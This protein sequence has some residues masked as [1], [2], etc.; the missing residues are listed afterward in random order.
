MDDFIF[1]L[2]I[3][4]VIAF[5][6]TGA[7]DA[8]DSKMDLLG[9]IILGVTTSVG[10][11]IIRDL[12]LGINP[13]K[14][15]VN[16][17]YI[18][19]ATISS[20]LTFAWTYY[21]RNIKKES[22]KFLFNQWLTTF[23]AIGLAVFTV[24]GMNVAYSL[25]YDYRGIVYVFVGVIT[26]VGGGILRDVLSQKMPYILE[27]NI[28]ASASIVGALVHYFLIKHQIFTQPVSMIISM[29]I[30]FTVR[31]VAAKF[32]LNLPKVR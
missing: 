10:G 4:G 13:P 16:P 20:L 18:Y 19:I 7:L 31:M 17:I 15:F 1:R 11:G 12:V 5:A 29:L 26:G 24:L 32:E 8:I 14:S 27:R 21:K 9:V 23:D 22:I 6:V 3:L 28:Y 25:S 2:E 30:I